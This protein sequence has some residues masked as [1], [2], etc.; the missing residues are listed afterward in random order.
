[1]PAERKGACE[2][3]L[4][5]AG[6][7]EE[8]G[9]SGAWLQVKKFQADGEILLHRAT[10]WPSIEAKKLHRSFKR[11]PCCEMRAAESTKAVIFAFGQEPP[12]VQP[13]GPRW[14]TLE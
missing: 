10:R 12:A 6:R 1:M 9:V 2:A 4:G 14:Y 3:E 13:T 11:G 8:M 5:P 7:E